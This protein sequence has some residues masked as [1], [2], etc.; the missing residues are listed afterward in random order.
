MEGDEENTL[1]KRVDD[2]SVEG[3]ATL[4]ED[5]KVTLSA[6]DAIAFM[7]DAIHCIEVTSTIPT[8]HFHLYGKGF[9]Q[10]TDRLIYDLQQGT[11]YS[12][13]DSRIAVDTSR[14]VI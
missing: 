5:C 3:R 12:D 1:Y 4:E 11:T 9:E 13:A 7:P 14:R 2:R 6:G 8:R 10:Q